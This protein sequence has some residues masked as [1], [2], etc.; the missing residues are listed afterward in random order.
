MS[1]KSGMRPRVFLVLIL[2][3]TLAAAAYARD[4]RHDL[5]QTWQDRMAETDTA[6]KAADYR[7][8]VQLANKTVSEM[9]ERLGT[10]EK[11]ARLF[12]TALTQKALAHAGLGERA[13]AA[14]YW[15]IA[16]GLDPKCAETDFEPYGDAARLL[17]ECSERQGVSSSGPV[18]QPIQPPKLVKQRKPKYPH[19]AHYFGVT[20]DLV[21]EVIVTSDG[22]V[23]EPRIVTPLAA[24]A[25]SYAALEAVKQWRFEPARL[26]GQPVEVVYSLT[27]R[28]KD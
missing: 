27:V 6:L 24:P 26:A 19:G 7:R 20:G 21:V 22:Q 9:T 16:L 8:A 4:D 28:Y 3:L 2:T 14:W 5:L 25:L 13:E 1:L 12:G 15:H 23:R 10:G 18:D 11:S 17:Q